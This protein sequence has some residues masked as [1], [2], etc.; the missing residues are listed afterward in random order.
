MEEKCAPHHR[1]GTGAAPSALKLREG[2]ASAEVVPSTSTMWAG[3]ATARSRFTPQRQENSEYGS[4][5]SIT[6]MKRAAGSAA[7]AAMTDSKNFRQRARNVTHTN[8]KQKDSDSA[9]E[10]D[11]K[12]CLCAAGSDLRA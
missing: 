10:V 9:R 3:D 12:T 4:R 11:R 1:R 8:T 2:S 6:Q 5:K 7:V